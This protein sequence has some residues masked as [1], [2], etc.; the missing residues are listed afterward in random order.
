MGLIVVGTVISV[1]GTIF[2]TPPLQLLGGIVV[3]VGFSRREKGAGEL[4]R[5]EAPDTMKEVEQEDMTR[6]ELEA[7]E[8][9]KD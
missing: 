1:V 7:L 9:P 6:D 4:P 5:E 2:P 8:E 3:L